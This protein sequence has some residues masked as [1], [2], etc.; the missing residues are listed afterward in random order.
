MSKMLFKYVFI[1]FGIN[2]KIKSMDYFLPGIFISIF[3]LLLILG[4]I[5]FKTQFMPNILLFNILFYTIFLGI[6]SI[7]LFSGQLEGLLKYFWILDI[8]IL[9]IIRLKYF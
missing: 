1:P 6:F 2:C 8:I 9:F 4:L 7:Q 5:N 3:G